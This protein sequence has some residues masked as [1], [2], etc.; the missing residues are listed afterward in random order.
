M[1]TARL[2]S[3]S[4]LVACTATAAAQPSTERLKGTGSVTRFEVGVG[5]EWLTFS[6]DASGSVIAGIAGVRSELD[7]SPISLRFDA[8]M[9]G[10]FFTARDNNG[11]P[12]TATQQVFGLLVGID[13]EKTF[14]P[15]YS[16]GPVFGIGLAPY[17]RSTGRPN[18]AGG[19]LFMAGVVLRLRHLLVR[20]Q[21]V[22]LDGAQPAV[23]QF[24]SY[25]PLTVGWRF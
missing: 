13:I 5:A 21:F 3:V 24:R 2:A 17:A 25:Y 20:Q 12:V 4:L 8:L 23:P 9:L 22:V 1:R 7:E 6:G 18:Y 15:D 19:S 10:R 16:V 11:Q 14:G